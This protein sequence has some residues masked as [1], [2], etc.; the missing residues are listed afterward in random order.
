MSMP[1][2]SEI[3]TRAAR[4]ADHLCAETEGIITALS[5]YECASVAVDEIDRSVEFLRNLELNC[6]YFSGVVQ[7]VTTFLPLNQPLYAT[8]C[9][10]IVPSFLA[11]DVALRPP[12]AMHQH[13]RKLADIVRLADFFP[14]LSVSYADRDEF[15][16]ERRRSS[17][18]VI[19]T[20]TPENAAK[21]RRHF[22]KSTLFILNGAGHNPLVVT[23]TA[24]IEDAVASAIRVVL[25]NQGQDCAGP[26]AILVH[27]VIAADFKELLLDRL[28]GIESKVGSYADR[29][30]VVGPNSDP[31]HT[32]KIS[33]M[34]RDLRE[35]YVYG[36]EINPVTGLIRPTVFERPLALGGNYKEFFAPVFYLQ[37]YEDD[38]QLALYFGD[39]QY[40]ANAMYVSLFGESKYIDGLAETA[41]H[42]RESIL[43]D[44][45]LH[46]VEKG[47]LPYGGQG[48]SASCLYVD[49]VRVPGATLPQRD[50]CQ[51]LIESSR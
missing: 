8:V 2:F 47:Y 50:I 20:G 13:Y 26:N 28:A 4:F 45:D 6:E 39:E 5:E 21:V 36:G 24:V 32:L 46:I 14:N 48:P 23:D 41:L 35:D 30:N 18:A 44:T 11:D 7:G 33:Q 40:A 37:P 3:K 27:S 42:T 17:S 15:V 19:F 51:Y 49:G 12:Q 34:F 29:N 16:A 10:G 22:R 38:E 31:D 9:F 43:R 25:Y 1:E